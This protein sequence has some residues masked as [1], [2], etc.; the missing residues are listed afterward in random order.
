MKTFKDWVLFF[1]VVGLV[2]CFIYNHIL[3]TRIDSLESDNGIMVLLLLLKVNECVLRAQ[4]CQRAAHILHKIINY[5]GSDP[6]WFRA[7]CC[8]CF[9]KI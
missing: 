8:A 6:C 1:C 4:A 2:L 7:F 9:T 3:S 5:I